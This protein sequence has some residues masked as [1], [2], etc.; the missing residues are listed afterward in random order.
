M[1]CFFQLYATHA[2]RND[3]FLNVNRIKMWNIQRGSILVLNEWFDFD[4][5]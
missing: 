5:I 3:E 2:T 4:T 1:P